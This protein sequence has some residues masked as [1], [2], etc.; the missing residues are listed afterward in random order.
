MKSLLLLIALA[1]SLIL[2]ACNTFHGMGR[3]LQAAGNW[4]QGHSDGHADTE[5]EYHEYHVRD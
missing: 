4:V 1:T 5:V 2:G 3:D